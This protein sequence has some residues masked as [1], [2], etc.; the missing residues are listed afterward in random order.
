MIALCVN[1]DDYLPWEKDLIFSLESAPDGK[2]PTVLSMFASRL[3]G[4]L[5]QAVEKARLYLP[6]HLKKHHNARCEALELE[7]E[8]FG[9]KVKLEAAKAGR[10]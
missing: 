1:L 7:P 5:Q 4:I 8:M 2:L 9:K 3:V 6:F 10:S